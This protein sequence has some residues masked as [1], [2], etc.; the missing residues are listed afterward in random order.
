MHHDFLG[1]YSRR[2][3]HSRIARY[4]GVSASTVSRVLA[5]AGRSRLSDLQPAEPV[6]RY[7]HEAPGDMLQIDTKSSDASSGPVIA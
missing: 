6:M 1:P 7:E 2:M 5:R 3:L 4:A